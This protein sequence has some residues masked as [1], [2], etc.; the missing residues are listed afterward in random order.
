M[1]RF[2][3]SEQNEGSLAVRKMSQKAQD[4]F[5]NTDV[6]AVYQY[7]DYEATLKAEEEAFEKD[8]DFFPG[9]LDV[10]KYAINNEGT[11][12][13]N[14]AFEEVERYLEEICCTDE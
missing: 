8:V 6:V 2:T 3:T 5:N 14:L 1:K 13:L 11:L 4:N 7:I 10:I 9:E 12:T